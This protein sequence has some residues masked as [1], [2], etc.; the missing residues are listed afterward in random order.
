MR[1]S[2][3]SHMKAY[4]RIREE[5]RHGLVRGGAV[6]WSSRSPFVFSLM[7]I[8]NEVFSGAGV[9]LRGDNGSIF[10]DGKLVLYVSKI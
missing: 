3:C 4:T 6:V 9:V 10:V 5:C 7:D 1:H 8:W 2:S